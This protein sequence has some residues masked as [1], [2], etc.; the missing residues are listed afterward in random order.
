MRKWPTV[1]E[2][3][4]Y[5]REQGQDAAAMVV[6]RVADSEKRCRAAAHNNLQALYALKDKYE[7]GPRI[8]RSY[9]SPA[10]SDG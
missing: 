5:L 10:E 6:E 7:P 1:E 8:A 2:V 9:R 3:A 4:A